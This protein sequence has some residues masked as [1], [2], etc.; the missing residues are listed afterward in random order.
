MFR[1]LLVVKITSKRLKLLGVKLS[2]NLLKLLHHP[3]HNTWVCAMN[4]V[5]D[6]ILEPDLNGHS[7]HLKENLNS[8]TKMHL[9]C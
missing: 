2:A 7:N 4:R 8:L 1:N 3:R 6:S 9:C 5:H